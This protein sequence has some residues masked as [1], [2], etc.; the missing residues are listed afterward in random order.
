[1]MD[2]SQQNAIVSGLRAAGEKVNINYKGVF[3]YFVYPESKARGILEVGDII[4]AVDGHPVHR[5]EELIEYLNANKKAGDKAKLT[6]LRDGVEKTADIELM[7][8]GADNQTEPGT[9]KKVGIGVRPENKME[10]DLPRKVKIKAED[11]GGPSAGMMFALEIYSQITPGDLTKGYKIA[12]TGTIN[13]EG[14][15]GQIGGIRHKIVAAHEQGAEIFFV[16]ADVGEHDTNAKDAAD[17][18]KKLGYNM[19]VVPVRTLQD[20]I[21]YLQKLPP[22]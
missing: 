1:M 2:T 20:A 7:E 6:F 17:E 22:K 11:I 10:L 14:E 9:P 8:L 15:V 21:D 16:P 5:S 4:T 12:G 18:A 13:L 3:V 19:K